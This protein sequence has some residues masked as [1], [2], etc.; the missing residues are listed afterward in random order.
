[1][2]RQSNDERHSGTSSGRRKGFV[3]WRGLPSH[4]YF[5]YARSYHLAARKLARMF[6]VDPGSISDFD[7]CPILSAYRY[8]IEL[9]LKVIVLGDGGN[10][11][12]TRPDELSVQK[13][14]SLS[15]LAQFVC[16]IVTNL[17]WGGEFK[18]E[19]C[20][21]LPRWDSLRPSRG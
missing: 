17:K 13:T 19:G 10:F 12:Q 5:L 16:Q 14:R 15:W 21:P 4:D 18:T 20:V 11:L 9:H 6:D 2:K 3:N 7:L 1:M 8:A